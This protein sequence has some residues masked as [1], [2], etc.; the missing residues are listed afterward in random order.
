MRVG[1]IEFESEYW[2]PP[3]LLFRHAKTLCRAVRACLRDP[4]RILQFSLRSTTPLLEGLSISLRFARIA[5]NDSGI[6][7]S[8]KRDAALTC[9][10]MIPSAMQLVRFSFVGS[11]TPLGRILHGHGTFI[12]CNSGPV[13]QHPRREQRHYPG[14]FAAVSQTAIVTF[15][16]LAVSQ[17]CLYLGWLFAAPT[18]SVSMLYSPRNDLNA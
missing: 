18:Y 14:L 1:N 16:R 8:N 11:E 3:F 12:N 13:L 7:C 5:C 6:I 4:R 10:A 2:V 15:G 17:A 9:Y